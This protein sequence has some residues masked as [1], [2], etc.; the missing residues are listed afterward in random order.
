MRDGTAIL[1]LGRIGIMADGVFVSAGPPKQSTAF[2]VL[3]LNAGRP[4]PIDSLIER[5]WD[6]ESPPAG[7]GALYAYVSRLRTL[8]APLPDVRLR[9]SDHAGY[10]L[11]APPER[12]DVYRMRRLIKEARRAA[13]VGDDLAATDLLR[14]AVGLWR[15]DT[16]FG[17]V[18]NRWLDGVRESLGWERLGALTE[19]YGA[20]L[21]AGRHA[22]V[23]GE[24]SWL[25]TAHPQAE[26]LVALLMHALRRCGQTAEAL[27][28][29]ERTRRRLDEEYGC[30]PGPALQASHRELLRQG[31]EAYVLPALPG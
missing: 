4:V 1:L 14:S 19:L 30:R 29:F 16:A 15:A 23:L 22:E 24:L 18:G 28:L 7:R 21:R 5:V 8:L 31:T 3:A 12:V 10:V 17:G 2:A 27:D 9:R 11:E 25:V 20:E 13:S 26:P 6:G